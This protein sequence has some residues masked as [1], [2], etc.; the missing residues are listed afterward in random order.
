VRLKEKDDKLAGLAMRNV[1]ALCD[2]RV[3]AR[4][5]TRQETE[6]AFARLT[7]TTDFSGLR[8]A[9]VVVE[10]APEDLGLKRAILHDVE[11]LVAPTCVYASTSTSIPVARIAE[12][13]THPD[14]IVGLHFMRPPA[15]ALLVEVVR[16]DRAASWAVAT[17]VALSKRQGKTAIVVRDGPGFYAMRVF[18]RFVSEALHLVGE[19]V[20]VE[21]V[22]TALSEWGFAT[23][24]L[25]ALDD[26]GVDV[27]ARVAQGLHGALGPRT[28]PP[29]A[30]AK[31][32]SAERLGRSNGRGFYRYRA[33]K[34]AVV[35]PRAYDALRV[36][37]G[38]RLPLEE[39]QMR[40]A[41]A[42]VNEAIRC[43]G[44]GMLRSP[45]DGDIGAVF[46][47]GFPPSRGGPFRYVDA[48]GAADIQ[49]RVQSYADRFG[50]RWLPAPRLV[51]LAKR[52]DRFFA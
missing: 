2:A 27:V 39:I 51:H 24:P 8:Q 33:D 4:H 26:I 21:A 15:E 45:R 49:R 22:D 12:A 41:L 32:L 19:G 38:T 35:D 28:P 14:R 23:G 11:A 9:D 5:A 31:L 3:A 29:G 40:C 46:G 50:E 17:A 6:Q 1:K 37:P 13:A 16:T 44:E 20:A 7:S 18:T 42:L 52:G 36:T 34:P 25:R 43:L 30:L 10:A 47:L 48:V